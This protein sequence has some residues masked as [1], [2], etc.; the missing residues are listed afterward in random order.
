M[1]QETKSM[2]EATS[3]YREYV[4][5]IRPPD[6][7]RGSINEIQLLAQTAR[8]WWMRTKHSLSTVLADGYF[9]TLTDVRLLKEDTITLVASYGADR[10]EH[11]I[12]I[13][14]AADKHGKASVSLLHRYERGQ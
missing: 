1:R 13:V 14:T 8:V 12:L 5:I 4:D 11:A 9:D 7:P 3:A 2:S 10:A 6:P